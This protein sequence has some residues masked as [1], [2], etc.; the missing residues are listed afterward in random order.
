MTFAFKESITLTTDASG[1]ATGYLGPLSGAIANIVYTKDDFADGVDF[2][3]TNETTGQN[4]WTES[5]V[6]ASAVR[7]PRQPTHGQDGTPSL[8]AV[9]GEP[10]EDKIYLANERIKIVVGSGGNAKSGTFTVIMGG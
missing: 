10:V 2:T 8:Y 9:G 4:I 5:D 1:D 7:A 6:N 3:I